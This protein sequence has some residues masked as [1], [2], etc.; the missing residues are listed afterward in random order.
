M[1]NEMC[2]CGSNHNE[3]TV[4]DESE[5]EKCAYAQRVLDS[6]HLEGKISRVHAQ[7]ILQILIQEL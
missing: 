4:V 5:K 7:E 3:S 1:E 6:F 2:F